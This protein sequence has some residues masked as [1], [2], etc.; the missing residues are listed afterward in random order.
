MLVGLAQIKT[1]NQHHT[2]AGCMNMHREYNIFCEERLLIEAIPRICDKD[3]F[4]FCKYLS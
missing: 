3:Q 4:L 2:C 1:H